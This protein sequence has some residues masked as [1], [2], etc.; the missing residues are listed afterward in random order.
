[1]KMRRRTLYTAV[2]H[3]KKV[4]TR[5]GAYPVV[6]VN[7]QEYRMDPQE[8]AVWSILNWRLLDAQGLEEYYEPMF[9]TLRL[10]ERRTLENCLG[11][12]VTRGLVAAGHGETD[13]EALYDLL[14]NLYVV[15]IS[16]SL[17]LRTVTFLKMI[18]LDGVSFS[19]AKQIFQ[20][21]RLSEGEA[22]VMALARQALLSTAELIRCVELGITDVSS[23]EK[24]MDALYGDADATSDNMGD[25][26]RSSQSRGPVTLSV[27]NLCLHKQI[28]FERV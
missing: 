10:E 16:E 23:D 19:R 3:F 20:K 11:R 6:L 2:G 13:F 12:L 28:I 1:M 5:D 25:L 8:M 4:V 24:V 26:M 15:P 27:A 18:L 14:S 17:P 9:Q 22:R 7:R 21:S